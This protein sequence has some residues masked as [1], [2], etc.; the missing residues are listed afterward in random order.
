VT[1]L[2][3]PQE[4]EAAGIGGVDQLLNFVAAELGAR[5]L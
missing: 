3:T 4:R 2:V 1:V 5:N